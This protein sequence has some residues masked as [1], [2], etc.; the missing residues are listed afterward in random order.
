MYFHEVLY[1]EKLISLLDDDVL[2]SSI[3]YIHTHIQCNVMTFFLVLEL[4]F[5]LAPQIVCQTTA[6]SS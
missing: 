3:R 2:R 5:L 4:S 1:V 6:E